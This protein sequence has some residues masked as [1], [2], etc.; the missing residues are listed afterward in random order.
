[1]SR[2]GSVSGPRAVAILARLALQR[3]L[4]SKT[5]WIVGVLALCP[6][7]VAS[8][9]GMGQDRPTNHWKDAY[10]ILV[11]FMVV[12]PPL[13]VAASV[14]EEIEERTYTYLWSRPLP[15]WAMVIGKLVAGWPV[16]AGIL[17]A[18]AVAAFQISGGDLEPL[19]EATLAR[20]LAG[21]VVGVLGTSLVSAGFAALA[22]GLAQ[23]LTYA[24]LFVDLVLGEI[25]FSLRNASITYHVRQLAAID[26]PGTSPVGDAIWCIAIGAVWLAIGLVRL[27]RAEY[28]DDR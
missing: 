24:Y 23:R 8:L 9:M 18:A 21:C 16:A 14:S 20:G 6:V 26:P 28:A 2:G 19:R 25:Y 7:V 22:P 15:R 17:G 13:V 11:I 1:V 12:V 10:E 27:R 4:R 5:L 3:L